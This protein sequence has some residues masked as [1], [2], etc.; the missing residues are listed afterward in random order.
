MSF[1]TPHHSI[2]C[3]VTA[4]NPPFSPQFPLDRTSKAVKIVLW[5][6]IVFGSLNVVAQFVPFMMPSSSHA[7]TH[8]NGTAPGLF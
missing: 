2:N 1:V 5:A 6:V 7:H 8:N 4:S 3:T